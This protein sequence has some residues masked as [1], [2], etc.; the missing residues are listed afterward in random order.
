MT[1]KNKNRI[2]KKNKFKKMK[3][4]TETPITV[5]DIF[6]MLMFLGV[7]GFGVFAFVMNNIIS[8]S[9]WNLLWFIPFG[10]LA[11]YMAKGVKD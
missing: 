7:S 4:T 2:E 9:N 11:H 3:E 1:K 10:L 6:E 5:E 8:Y